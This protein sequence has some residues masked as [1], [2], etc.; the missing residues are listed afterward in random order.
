MSSM[1]VH[2]T[3][4]RAMETALTHSGGGVDFQ[5]FLR[6]VWNLGVKTGY[7]EPTLAQLQAMTTPRQQARAVF[8]SID[9]DHSGVLESFELAE[10]LVGWGCPDNEVELYLQ[11]VDTNK[12]GMI[13]FEDEFF[14]KMVHIWSFGFENVLLLKATEA[15]RKGACPRYG[16]RSLLAR[17]DASKRPILRLQ[18]GT[19]PTQTRRA[20]RA[21]PS[22]RRACPS[23]RRACPSAAASARTREHNKN[24]PGFS[25]STW[26]SNP[27][28]AHR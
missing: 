8:D 14:P 3:V 13:D 22:G 17:A 21:C 19:P 5:R 27:I 18:D 11:H 16:Y 7:E 15:E 4:R 1:R 24:A 6:A 10:L 28:G 23:G 2:P 20:R 26:L 25:G 9:L 12:D